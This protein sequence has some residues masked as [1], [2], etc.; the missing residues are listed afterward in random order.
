MEMLRKYSK[1]LI[2]IPF[3]LLTGC[4]DNI[5]AIEP[6]AT[7]TLEA[8]KSAEMLQYE[9]FEELDLAD[10]ES[11]KSSY[12]ISQK[13]LAEM[14]I[15]SIKCYIAKNYGN[16]FREHFK[17]SD[18]TVLTDEDFLNLRAFAYF[19]LFNSFVYTDENGNE[20]M[21][22][23]TSDG[24]D[25][26][27]EV[28]DEHFNNL[29]LQVAEEPT[30]TE[31]EPIEIENPTETREEFINRLFEET[32]SKYCQTPEDEESYLTILN[33][34]SDEEITELMQKY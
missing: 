11:A 34:L 7:T 22:L 21:L 16:N 3:I 29:E 8:A 20:N 9:E 33:G 31:D 14:D 18:D 15:Y 26:M 6:V 2:I 12:E 19:E 23:D 17:I 30:E 13:E 28:T 24:I 5:E 1:I 10:I 25:I 27:K 32:K 4:S